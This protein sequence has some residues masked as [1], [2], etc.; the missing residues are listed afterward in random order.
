MPQKRKL[1]FRDDVVDIANRS[2]SYVFPYG[3]IKCYKFNIVALYVEGEE[4]VEKKMDVYI[5]GELG[6]LKVEIVLSFHLIEK[7]IYR[8][9]HKYS[10]NKMDRA[11]SNFI[12]GYFIK[13]YLNR[14]GYTILD[15]PLGRDYP[16]K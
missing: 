2:V 8:L 15:G 4:N 16:A 13:K 11:E 10:L 7:K 3:N 6:K 5:I 14:N 12:T 9:A 1:K